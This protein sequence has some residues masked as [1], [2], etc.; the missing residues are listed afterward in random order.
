MP[1]QLPKKLLASLPLAQ[2]AAGAKLTAFSGLPKT[3][4]TKKF[5]DYPLF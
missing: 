3:P 5:N 4:H 1:E 2:P